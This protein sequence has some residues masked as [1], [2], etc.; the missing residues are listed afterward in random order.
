MVSTDTEIPSLK[1]LENFL[2]FLSQPRNA[3]TPGKKGP[4]F[5]WSFIF[6]SQGNLKPICFDPAD[7]PVNPF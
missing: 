2:T 1:I 6:F 5:H 7:K 4:I 3:V